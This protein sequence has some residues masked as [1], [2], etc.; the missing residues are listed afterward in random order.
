[1]SMKAITSNKWVLLLVICL[2]VTNI[3]LGIFAFTSKRRPDYSFKNQVGLTEAQ[4]KV[5]DE[6]KKAYFAEMKPYWE[7]VAELKDSL[8][9]R[10]GDAELSDSTIESYVNKWHEINR[11]SD[12]QMFKHFR[13]M[14][15]ECTAEQ[16]PVYDSVVRKMMSR[17]RR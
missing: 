9:Q 4:S 16:L 2:I 8:Y 14:R 10:M 1:M 12:I 3:A 7:R 11:N 13:E 6:K 15:K 5:F 17:R